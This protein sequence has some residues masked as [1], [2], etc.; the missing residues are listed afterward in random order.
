MTIFKKLYCGQ[1]GDEYTLY[2][3]KDDEAGVEMG[4]VHDLWK[5]KRRIM[6]RKSNFLSANIME[7]L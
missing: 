7:Q 5:V 3:E 4:Y 2:F 1:C 6:C